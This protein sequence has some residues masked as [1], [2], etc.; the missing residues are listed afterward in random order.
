[1]KLL[2]N[3]EKLKKIKNEDKAYISKRKNILKKRLIQLDDINQSKYPPGGLYS[4]EKRKGKNKQTVSILKTHAPIKIEEQ[5]SIKEKENKC[6][7]DSNTNKTVIGSGKTVKFN[8][9]MIIPFSPSDGKYINDI[10][11]KSEV[12]KTEPDAE[13]YISKNNK[14]KSTLT[15]IDTKIK[16]KISKD[17]L[18]KLMKN[19]KPD[20]SMQNNISNTNNNVSV[21][22]NSNVFSRKDSPLHTSQTKPLRVTSPDYMVDISRMNE[23]DEILKHRLNFKNKLLV[24]D[25]PSKKNNKTAEHTIKIPEIELSPIKPLKNQNSNES[26][27]KNLIHNQNQGSQTSKSKGKLFLDNITV[28]K[29]KRIYK[30]SDKNMEKLKQLKQDKNKITLEEYQAKIVKLR[31]MLYI[32]NIIFL[33]NNF[34]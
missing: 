21:Q 15:P 28:K 7:N 16:F 27:N 3:D 24:R 25:F 6:Y 22:Q 14:N 13:I 18:P 26:S 29:L 8:F 23:K 10:N 1:M 11:P 19:E 2:T 4:S 20:C 30:I 12:T 32:N 17:K 9:P 5:Y 34:I 31:N 33:D